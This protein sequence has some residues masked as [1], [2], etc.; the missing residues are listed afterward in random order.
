MTSAGAQVARCLPCIDSK[1]RAPIGTKG[2]ISRSVVMAPG[3]CKH[4]GMASLNVG[5]KVI[6]TEG[7]FKGERG[8]IIDKK[9]FGEGLV[10]ALE[11]NGKEIKTE[12][13]H[14]NLVEDD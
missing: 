7:D 9:L 3:P 5:D 10:V 14:V 4:A 8:A 12:E 11:R 2:T 6:I 13:D 1:G